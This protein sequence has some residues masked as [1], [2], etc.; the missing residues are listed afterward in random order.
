M[1]KFISSDLLLTDAD[2]IAHQVNSFG[3]MGAGVALQIKN[4]YPEAFLEYKQLCSNY[5]NKFTDLQ[6]T[7][8]IIDV[9]GKLIANLFSQ[10]GISRTYRTTSYESLYTCLIKLKRYALLNHKSIAIPYKIGCGLAGGDWSNCVYKLI[11]RVYKD[12]DVTLYIH[13]KEV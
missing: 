1:I 2:I 3:V 8:Q 11:E 5:H 12:S 4:K 13:K 6:G 10:N 9:N 7:V